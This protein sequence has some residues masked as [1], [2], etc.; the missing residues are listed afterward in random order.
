MQFMGSQRVG[1]DFVTEKQRHKQKQR[2]KQ[3]HTHIYIYITSSYA[4]HLL[5]DWSYAYVLPI[6]NNDSM[7][8]GMNVFSNHSFLNICQGAGLLDD[9]ATLFIGGF[10]FFLINFY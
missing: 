9:M 8:I 10:F 7:N 6:V 3:R 2:Q 4:N 1:H 5:M